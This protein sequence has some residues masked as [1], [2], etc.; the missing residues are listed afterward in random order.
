[1]A[2]S[3]SRFFVDI[4]ILLLNKMLFEHAEQSELKLIG[5]SF[6]LPAQVVVLFH[7]S[8]HVRAHV[9]QEIHLKLL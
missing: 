6:C 5:L 4:V 1:M 9:N 7:N 2:R 8:L 3:E